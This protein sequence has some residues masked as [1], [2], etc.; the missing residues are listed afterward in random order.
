M[1]TA[2]SRRILFAPVATIAVTI[3]AASTP[4][5]AQGRPG[6]MPQSPPTGP[7]TLPGAPKTPDP[8]PVPVEEIIKRLS[9]NEEA[10]LHARE[11]FTF[12]KTVRIQELDDK[13]QT[14]GEFQLVTDT[15]VGSDG[16]LTEKVVSRP[17]STMTVLN[18]VEE[19]TDLLKR[20]PLFPLTVS[21]EPK[22][23]LTYL[24]K[25]KLDEI[26]AYIFQVKPKQVERTKALFD[27]VIWVDTAD[28][29]IVKTTGK[30][31]TEL[32]EVKPQ[33]LPF[34]TFDSLRENV[35]AKQWFPAY[36]RSDTTIPIKTGDVHIR[37]TV[38]W[39]NYKPVTATAS[40][41]ASQPHDH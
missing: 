38:L 18:V 10:M 16:K 19:D 27:G 15:A 37:L 41:P 9:A 12:R 40:Q 14:T 26:E 7:I 21:Q 25:Q 23:N 35:A 39:Q 34:S 3:L 2:S 20:I 28:F 29:A 33:Q 22:Y 32:G 13:G 8:P 11:G 30:W 24:G 1:H 6:P 5:L 36:M 17:T 4:S 31:I